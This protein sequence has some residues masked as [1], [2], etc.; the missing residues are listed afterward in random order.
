[1]SKKSS[2]KSNY[3]FLLNWFEFVFFKVT[4]TMQREYGIADY[5]FQ[6]ELKNEKHVF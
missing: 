5:L 2:F 6:K 1:M 4:D 3:L